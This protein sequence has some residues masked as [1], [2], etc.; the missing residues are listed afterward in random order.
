MGG[1]HHCKVQQK[2]RGQNLIEIYTV[3]RQF[4]FTK[5]ITYNKQA[6]AEFF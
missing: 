6:K 4:D 5:Y 3:V 2:N 1:H